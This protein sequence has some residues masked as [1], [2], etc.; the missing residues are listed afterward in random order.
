M[1]NEIRSQ[2]NILNDQLKS[3]ETQEREINNFKENERSLNEKLKENENIVKSFND[4][5]ENSKQLQ[6][7]VTHTEFIKI[8]HSHI[9]CLLFLLFDY[10]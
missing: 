9:K 2:Q 7:E 3:L 4:L 8:L 6:K 1:E 5:Q 10:S